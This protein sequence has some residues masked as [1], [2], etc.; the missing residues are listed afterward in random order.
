MEKKMTDTRDP[1]EKAVDRSAN[2]KRHFDL[3]ERITR[4]ESD[5]RRLLK[6]WRA[7][8]AQDWQYLVSVIP[9]GGRGRFWKAVLGEMRAAL[10]NRAE[11]STPER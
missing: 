1:L 3:S 8:D 2:W 7:V 11:T 10:E 6:P 9:D 5:V 4:A